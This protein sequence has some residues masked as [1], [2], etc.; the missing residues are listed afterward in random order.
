MKALA[1]YALTVDTLNK[2]DRAMRAAP[3]DM[4]NDPRFRE[5]EKIGSLKEIPAGTNPANVEFMI[6]HEADG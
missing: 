4:S 2:V 6:E 1:T 3:A 5:S